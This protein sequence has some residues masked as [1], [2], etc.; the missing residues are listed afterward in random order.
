MNPL[1]VVGIL[2]GI[3]LAGALFFIISRKSS[4]SSSLEG[5]LLMQQKQLEALREQL[6]GSLEGNTQTVGQQMAD[7]TKSVGARLD[8][9]QRVVTDLTG[10]LGKLEEATAKVFDVGKDIASLQEILRAPKL[11]GTLGELFLGDLL[12]QVLPPENFQLQAKFIGGETV[13][14]LIHLNEFKV[15]IDAK[16]PLENFRRIIDSP[17]EEARKI[18]RRE[19]LSDVKKHVDAIARKY[20]RPNEGT[21]EFALMYIPAENIYYEIIIKDESGDVGH[22]ILGYALSQHVIPVS[23]NNF[24]VYLQTVLLGLKGMRIEKSVKEVLVQLSQ[25]RGDVERFATDFGKVRTHL[26]NAQTA[27]AAADKRLEK[28]TDHLER[29]GSPSVRDPLGE[30]PILI[31]AA[32]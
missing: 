17:T 4:T 19:F 10:K 2:S 27:F 21:S 24:Y 15:P 25:V 8:N 32:S 7:L 20:I 14:A 22:N 6:R 3:A 23:P 28:L 29:L 13:D 5:M 26:G 1:F 16:F 18:M 31:D 30:E 9:T 11:R 12:S